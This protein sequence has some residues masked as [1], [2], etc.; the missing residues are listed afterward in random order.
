VV[1]TGRRLA[2][3]AD[4]A[5]AERLVLD[6]TDPASID[7]AMAAAGKLEVVINNAAMTV[8]EPVEAVPADLAEQ[9]LATNVLGPLRVMQAALPTMREQGAGRILNISSPAGRFA[10]PLEGVYSASKAALEMLSEAVRFEAGHFGVQVTIIQPGTI[11]TDMAEREQKFEL[12]DYAPLVTQYVERFARYRQRRAP[13]AEQIASEITD[14][15]E[16]RRL[17]LR[18]PVGLRSERLFARLSP[19]LLGRL[20]RSPYKW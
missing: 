14:L 6:L 2:D 5:A 18:V 16:D 3:L 7:L 12:P 4:L 10:P 15:L 17:P 1:A 19:G 11:A 20:V 8:S 13:S 9:V